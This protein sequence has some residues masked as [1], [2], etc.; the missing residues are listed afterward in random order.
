MPLSPQKQVAGDRDG[1]TAF[2]MD[3]KCE[4]L[5]ISTLERAIEQAREGRLQILDKML[6]ACPSPRSELPASVPKVERMSVN[7]SEIGKIIGP[8]GKM[9]RSMIEE[10]ELANIDIQDDGRVAV[11]GM[12]IV[13]IR[14]AMTQIEQLV[15]GGGGKAGPPKP[16][17][18]GPLPEEGQIFRQRV[19]VSVKNF[20]VFVELGEDYPGLE[21]LCHI[22][23]LAND[24]VRSI[25]RFLKPGDKIDVKVLG[26]DPANGKLQLSRKAVLNADSGAR[27]K[28]PAAEPASQ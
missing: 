25:E 14:A 18:E 9:I 10:F 4:G 12:D 23:E 3:I 8:G 22:S 20:G 5:S 21:G 27:R 6:E 19:I 1:I 26:T 15:G 16:V 13:N 28:A 7:P 24:R 11:S 17:Y 2:Q